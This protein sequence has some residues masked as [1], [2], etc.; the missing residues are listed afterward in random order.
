MKFF[1]NDNAALS[2]SGSIVL[3]FTFSLVFSSILISWMLLNAYGVNVAGMEFPEFQANTQ[4]ELS[5][6]DTSKGITYIGDTW[7]FSEGNGRVSTGEDSYILFDNSG[8]PNAG[9]HTNTYHISNPNQGDYSLVLSYSS[10]KTVEV[11]VSD[12]G[13]HIMDGS[14]GMGFLN[15]EIYFYPYENANKITPVVIQTDYDGTYNQII[16][17]SGQMLN[18][19]MDGN[20][21]FSTPSDVD[22]GVQVEPIVKAYYGGIGNKNNIGLTLQGFGTNDNT[23]MSDI[24]ALINSIQVWVTTLIKLIVWNVPEEYLPW[25]LNMLFVKSQGFALGVA[26]WQWS[27]GGN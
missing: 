4:Y 3:F 10:L 7:T 22:T 26:F 21:V 12:D 19:Y 13:F 17:N 9:M 1:N 11:V 14:F 5:S 20:L 2:S 25:E 15:N 16:D 8:S 18:L 27:R 24:T 23:K 6:N